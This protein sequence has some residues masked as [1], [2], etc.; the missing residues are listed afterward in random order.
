M[1]SFCLNRICQK[2]QSQIVTREN[3]HK[4]TSCKKGAYKMLMK[5]TQGANLTNIV[6]APFLYISV[7]SAFF[8]FLLNFGCTIFLRK[9][10][11]AEAAN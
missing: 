7:F 6:R 5:L 11:G 2:L 1:S 8:K 4:K 3:R 10:I 9:N